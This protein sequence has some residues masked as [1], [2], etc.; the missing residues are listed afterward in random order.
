[1][2]HIVIDG[3]GSPGS[4]GTPIG[5]LY[6]KVQTGKSARDRARDR[7]LHRL[8]QEFPLTEVLCYTV[9]RRNEVWSAVLC[10][11]TVYL[12]PRSSSILLCFV[13]VNIVYSV[14]FFFTVVD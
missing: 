1:M 3:A 10:C 4:T 9:L 2:V 12:T 7:L 5:P 14:P 13:F 11:Y 8:H 6:Y